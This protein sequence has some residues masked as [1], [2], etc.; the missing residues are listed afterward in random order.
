[1]NKSVLFLY[2]FFF[3][4]NLVSQ[5][6]LPSGISI[7]TQ[8]EIDDFATNYPGCT[9]VLGPVNIDGFNT[10]HIQNLDG[11]SHITSI[12]SYL[13]IRNNAA[14]PNL[15]GLVSLKNIGTAFHIENNPLISSLAG[16]D[17]L[18]SIG[19]IYLEDQPN[20]LS[21]SGLNDSLTI[22]YLHMHDNVGISDFTGL[23]HLTELPTG[24]TLFDSD[25]TGFQGL[26]NVTHIG[27]DFFLFNLSNITNFQGLN[28]LTNIGGIFFHNNTSVINY[29]GLD[30]LTSVAGGMLVVGNNQL[31]GFTHLMSLTDISLYLQITANHLIKNL[32]GLSNLTTLNGYIE[33]IN[34]N[35][36]ESLVGLGN[37][38]LSGLTSSPLGYEIDVRLNQ[39]LNTCAIDFIC[40]AIDDPN[41]NLDIENN[42]PDC[43]S[44]TEVTPF[45]PSCLV[46]NDNTFTGNV[47][48]LWSNPNNWSKLALPDACTN[49]FIPNNKTVV[50]NNNFTAECNTIVV[51][52][53]SVLNVQ[54]G[55]TLSVITD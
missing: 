5:S 10:G 1:M 2:L 33:I 40:S 30:N 38:D 4:T 14:L 55:S 22:G 37:I 48:N 31:T 28:S 49:V 6:C 9:E 16:P 53:S 50:V 13:R 12:G 32:N 25:I 3:S 52:L 35:D 54:P 23:E 34:N 24:I 51:P 8:Q 17:S 44:I 26:N 20:L 46:T 11:L 15:S 7:S 18:S 36:L 27:G 19:G 43:N 45:C 42:A 39:S 41:I 47:N 29:A 21:F